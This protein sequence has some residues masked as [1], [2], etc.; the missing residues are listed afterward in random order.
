[1]CLEDC[2]TYIVRQNLSLKNILLTGKFVAKISDLGVAKVIRAVSKKTKTCA[3]GIVDFMGPEA[4]AEIPEYGSPLDV[5]SYGGVTLHIMANQELPKPLHYVET[6]SKTR[7]LV[8]LS[9]VERRQKRV[10]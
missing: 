5:F 4:L 2:V 7:K 6:D 9:E 3:P 8:A 1:M 10:V